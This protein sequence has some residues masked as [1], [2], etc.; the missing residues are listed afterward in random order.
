M[1]CSI[2]ENPTVIGFASSVLFAFAIFLSY[3]PQHLLIIS[4]RTSEGLSPIFLLLGSASGISSLSNLILVTYPGRV[5]CSVISR[6]GCLSSQ[7]G[8][9]QV[10]VQSISYCLILVL[11]VALAQDN[12]AKRKQLLLV[13]RVFWVYT[14]ISFGAVVY[15]LYFQNESFSSLLWFANF[16][17]ILSSILGGVQ[18]FPQ[19][20]TTYKL[21]HAGTLSISMMFMQTPGGFLWSFLLYSQPGSRWSSWLPYLTAAILQLVLLIMCLYYRHFTIVESEIIQEIAEDMVDE[22]TPLV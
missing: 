17:G 1:D 3:L 21:Q 16:C 20:A 15:L 14:L 22:R 6:F 13:Y 18:Y 7:L 11:C 4:R 19:I 8:L 9:L 10:G 2:Y 5:C 12:S